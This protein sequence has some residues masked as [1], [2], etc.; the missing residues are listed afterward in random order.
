[1]AMERR[2]YQRI[3]TDNSIQIMNG[4]GRVLPALALDI[5]L[6]GMQLLCD[7]LTGQQ[8]AHRLAEADDGLI[9]VRLP[10]HGQGGAAGIDAYCRVV[11][12]RQSPE[13]ECR[14]GLQYAELLGGSYQ[15]LESFVDER[16]SYPEE[17]VGAARAAIH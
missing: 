13:D 11:Y 14:L 1:M 2:Q 9:R 12:L 7:S 16:V 8:I 4:D 3:V 6:L 5:S 10:L 15:W 17:R